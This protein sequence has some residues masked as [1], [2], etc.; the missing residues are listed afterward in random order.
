VNTDKKELLSQ[1]VVPVIIS[2]GVSAH[3]LAF[4]LYMK[5]GVFP[6]LCGSRRNPLDLFDP[7]TDFLKVSDGGGAL[8]TRALKDYSGEM[9]DY[10]LILL[11]ADERDRLFLEERAAELESFYIIASSYEEFKNL[12]PIKFA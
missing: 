8:L 12:P 1:L 9:S 6:V 2:N 3:R 10:I 11:P 4:R 5:Y 7:F